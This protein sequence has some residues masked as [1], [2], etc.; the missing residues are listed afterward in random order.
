MEV[1]PDQDK[2]HYQ[3]IS[4]RAAAYGG[5]ESTVIYRS[6]LAAAPDDVREYR[7]LACAYLADHDY[8]SAG[9]VVDAGL[10][11][12]PGDPQ[13]L[14]FRGEV[15]ARQDD[16]DGALADWRLAVD[17]NPANLGPLYSSAFLL[18]RRRRV[19]DAITAWRE[20]VERSLARGYTLDTE[21][22]LREI[23]RLEQSGGP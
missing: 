22:P 9:Q 12:A 1:D 20:I 3:L 4:A 2:T 18:E 15:R 13:L 14:E 10:R 5:Y 6:R 23:E 17:L 16:P 19:A 11:L 21:W 8:P 7:F